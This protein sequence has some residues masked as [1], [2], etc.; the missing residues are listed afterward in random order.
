MRLADFTLAVTIYAG[1]DLVATF[2]SPATARG[3]GGV[4]LAMALV[5]LAA[6]HCPFFHA[7]RPKN[8]CRWSCWEKGKCVQQ[9]SVR[10]WFGVSSARR[11]KWFLG[12][13]TWEPRHD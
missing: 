4:I 2:I 5:V 7:G 8:D 9:L 10:W 13:L 3:I 1:L 6:R 11:P 12:I